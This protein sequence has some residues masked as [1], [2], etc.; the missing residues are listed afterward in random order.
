[1]R[2]IG[3]KDPG[4]LVLGLLL[5]V[6]ALMILG[7]AW[8]VLTLVMPKS[9]V[10][11]PVFVLL[12]L[13][14]LA[15][16]LRI[17]LKGVT[18]RMALTLTDAALVLHGIRPSRPDIVVPWGDLVAVHYGSLGDKHQAIRL[19]LRLPDAAPPGPGHSD[20]PAPKTK[21]VFVGAHQFAENDLA[22]L[23]AIRQAWTAAGY[24]WRQ[25]SGVPVLGR[26]SW[27]VTASQ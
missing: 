18:K 19:E 8:H 16:I 23:E 17:S 12:G 10:V 7:S 13:A 27:V 3:P 24:P 5:G 1:M 14:S 9:T 25:V 4:D 26:T 2:V 6:L 20:R 15:L 11:T 21:M 22:V